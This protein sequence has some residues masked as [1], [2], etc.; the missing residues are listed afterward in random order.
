MNVLKTLGGMCL[1]LLMLGVIASTALIFYVFS[2]IIWCVTAKFDPNRKVL[3]RFTCYCLAFWA[4]IMPTWR[5]KVEGR[6]KI[7]KKGVYVIIANHQ[8]QLDI[9]MTALLFTH[10]KWISKAEILKVPIVG[11]QMALNRY[12][13][14]RRG[15]V[16]SIAKMMADCDK[17]LDMGSS[18][19]LFPE[20]T[21]SDDG[22]IKE[23][24]PGAFI[25]A[26]KHK[27]PVLPIVIA[28]TREALPKNS[29]MTLGIHQIRLKVLDEIPYEEYSRHTH[30]EN[31]EST[32]LLM[33]K[34]LKI[35]AKRLDLGL[36]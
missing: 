13:L 5:I 18:I 21:R 1:S 27:I 35:M 6:E 11:W 29:L 30:E 34:H 17:A 15:Y 3:H 22:Q 28:G 14:I 32:R 23:F 36:F 8:S 33:A 20:G 7:K 2:L 24:K 19:L 26:E 25:L 16:N 12:I 10:F 31:L 4:F 9:I